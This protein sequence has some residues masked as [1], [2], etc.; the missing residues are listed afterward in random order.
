[1]KGV[2]APADARLTDTRE[3]RPAPES[4]AT[5]SLH[6]PGAVVAIAAIAATSA[7]ALHFG[8]RWT[9]LALLPWS[10]G[11]ILLAAID[12]EH[13]LLPKH[14]IYITGTATAAALTIA[15][16]ATD[17]WSRLAAAAICAAVAATAYAALWLASPKSLGFGDVRL[18]ALAAL[19]LGWL[20]PTLAIV[21]LAASQLACLAATITLIATGRANRKTEMPLGTFIAIAS[22]ATAI[23]LGR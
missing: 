7:L 3:A 17:N 1:M 16:A 19:M 9:L 5:T 20:S 21:G 22:I 15:A 4:G 23:A 18:A 8:I 13:H 6:L 12:L 14:T 10:T 2:W 11:L